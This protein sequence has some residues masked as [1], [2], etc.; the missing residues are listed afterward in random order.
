[1]RWLQR[2]HRGFPEQVR[3]RPV[4]EELRVLRRDRARGQD[5]VGVRDDQSTGVRVPG[6]FDQRVA[7]AG[8]RQLRR[9]AERDVHRLAQVDDLRRVQA[10][11]RRQ[12]GRVH[13]LRHAQGGAGRRVHAGLRVHDRQLR[14]G[15][16]RP[17]RRR[18]VRGGAGAGGRRPI[19]C[20]QL[21]RRRRLLRFSQRLP[22]GQ[23]RGRGVHQRQRVRQHLQPDHKHVLLL[24]G[25]AVA[26]STTTRGTLLSLL[27]VG[28]GLVFTRARRRRR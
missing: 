27:L 28:A 7:G 22:A 21:V 8:A 23:G 10:G 16:D 25:C 9:Q 19:L 14:G 4:L 3:G 5:Q 11:S 26:G 2:W 17:G 20:G 18:D 13:G 6:C 24:L 12:H 15:I 1:M